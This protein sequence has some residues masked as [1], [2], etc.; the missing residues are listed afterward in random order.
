MI[1][2]MRTAAGVAALV[3]WHLVS[4]LVTVEGQGLRRMN[5]M[6][7]K[8]HVG[9]VALVCGHVIGYGCTERGSS[10]ELATNDRRWSFAF[11]IPRDV[12]ETFGPHPEEQHLQKLIC[13]AGRIERLKSRHEIVLTD[14]SAISVLPERSGLP[15]F[16]PGVARP[17]DDGV[18]LPIAKR[19]VKPQYTLGAMRDRVEGTVVVQAIVNTDGRIGDLRVIRNLHS[20][21]DQA[22]VDAARRWRFQS[23]T[24]NGQPVPVVVVIELT[25]TLRS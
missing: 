3:T 9:E 21:L 6:V 20:E 5:T 7:A 12:R 11:R 15:P 17:C 14:P 2:V 23:G 16:A 25:F 8:E 13:A 18:T 4:L 1:G 24:L 19:E 22:A 10:I